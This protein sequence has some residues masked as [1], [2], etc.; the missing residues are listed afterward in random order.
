MRY[1]ARLAINLNVALLMLV[2]GVVLIGRASNPRNS[3]QALGFDLCNGIPCY[4]GMTPGVTAW[5]PVKNF[6]TERGALDDPGKEYL[7]FTFADEHISAGAP[8]G[9]KYLTSISLHDQRD[10]QANSTLGDVLSLL[11]VPCGIGSEYFPGTVT[12]YYPTATVNVLPERQQLTPD[13]RVINVELIDF[14][15]TAI[16]DDARLCGRQGQAPWLG[17]ATLSYYDAHG[18]RVPLLK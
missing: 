5:L 16:N 12:V 7:E 4:M 17:F 3:L 18:A 6:M 11:G 14:K 10:I 1:L 15:P 13:A 2:L 9:A 8:N